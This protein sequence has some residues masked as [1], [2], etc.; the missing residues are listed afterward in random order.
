MALD[1]AASEF[2][3]LIS[4]RRNE[5]LFSVFEPICFGRTLFQH[6]GHVRCTLAREDDREVF[7]AGLCVDSLGQ[8]SN[9]EIPAALLSAGRD[10]LEGLLAFEPRLAGRYIVLYTRGQDA[11]IINDATGAMQIFYHTQGETC[12]AAA[13]GL[14]ASA[15]ELPWDEKML[16]I[17][18]GADYFQPMPYDTTCVKDVRCLLPGHYLHLND[19]TV[20]RFQFFPP[21]TDDPDRI[22]S[23]TAR[24][25]DNITLA[26]AREHPLLCPITG[27]WDS[28]VNLSFL[29]KNGIVPETYTFDHPEFTADTEDLTI[30]EKMCAALGISHAVIP[31][32]NEDKEEFD[33]IAAV[34]GPYISDRTVRLARTYRFRYGS[35][36][37]LLTGD[38]VAQIGKHVLGNRLSWRSAT[39]KFLTCKI[40]NLTSGAERQI[41]RQLEE[42]EKTGCREGA[43]DLFSL[44]S[45]C[46]RWASRISTIYA[47]HGI[48]ALNLYNCRSV[49]T[50]W[51][52]LGVEDRCQKCV[53]KYYLRRNAPQLLDYPFN[54]RSWMDSMKDRAFTFWLATYGKYWL[55]KIRRR[56]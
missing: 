16:P 49:L 26:Y 1:L 36:R 2:I 27:G 47:M 21:E 39:A 29:I 5:A 46:G 44:E 30:P 56:D 11:W 53:H 54:S 20:T 8:L 55:H 48:Q 18:H 43:F 15:L 3:Y 24:Q 22:L 34:M 25:I 10:G 19:S 13:E 42:Y 23:E 38:T 50:A 51:M 37:I 32:V 41:R 6:G 52:S 40:H 33:Q 17:R 7:V 45:R 28:R 12:L 31:D 4:S 9:E 14:V 35:D